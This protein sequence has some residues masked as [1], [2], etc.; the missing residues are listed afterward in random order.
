MNEANYTPGEK[1][2]RISSATLVKIDSSGRFSFKGG[3]FSRIV[4]VVVILITFQATRVQSQ[5]GGSRM[6][7]KTEQVSN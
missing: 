6:T 7:T 1:N 5:K 4:L 3:V 2:P